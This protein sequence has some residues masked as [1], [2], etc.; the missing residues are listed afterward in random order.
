MIDLKKYIDLEK[1]D[2][3][4]PLGISALVFVAVFAAG[5]GVGKSSSS[6]SSKTAKRS[7]N[8]T[9]NS[10]AQTK[11]ESHGNSNVGPENS[12]TA[13]T[14]TPTAAASTGE[15]AVKGS[16]SKIYHVPGGAFYEKTN[17][18]QCFANEDEAVAAGYKKSSR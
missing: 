6:D 9:T 18:A 11:T 16:K 12:N 2:K 14:K 17:A 4:K 7:L 5:F 13:T 1:L 15:C 10:P 3:L 8:Y